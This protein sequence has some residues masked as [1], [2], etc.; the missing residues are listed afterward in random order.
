MDNGGQYDR[1]RCEISEPQ[2]PPIMAP[3]LSRPAHLICRLLKH[4][5]RP[6]TGAVSSVGGL[7]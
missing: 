3:S 2:L 6:R 1:R 5:V 7:V 4:H